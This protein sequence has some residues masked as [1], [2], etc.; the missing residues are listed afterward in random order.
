MVGVEV[1]ATT[2]GNR[3]HGFALAHLDAPD[4][5]HAYSVSLTLQPPTGG[6]NILDLT[7]NIEAALASLFFLKINFGTVWQKR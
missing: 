5:G 3:A 1:K 4:N 2:F 7:K 6:V